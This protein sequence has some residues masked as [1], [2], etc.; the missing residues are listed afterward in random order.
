MWIKNCKAEWMREYNLN[1]DE[2]VIALILAIKYGDWTSIQALVPLQPDINARD[3][4]GDWTPLMYAVHE[5]SLNTV[6]L[7]VE[8]GSDVNLRGSFEPEDDFAL[9]I[10][11][12][13]GNKEIFDYLA[14]L[15]SPDMQA[16]AAKNLNK[17]N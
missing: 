14:P 15:T 5:Q 1:E 13:A 3:S 17:R 12:Y 16:T 9:N 7:L 11:A 10:A 6:K 2:I 8:A 4:E